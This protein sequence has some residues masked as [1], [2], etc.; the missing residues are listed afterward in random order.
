[1]DPE[2][3]RVTYNVNNSRIRKVD[4][5][6]N[7]EDHTWKEHLIRNIFA[8]FDA[9]EILKIRLPNFEAD[10]FVAW[11]AEKHGMFT[12]KS[13]YNLALDLRTSKP[14][15]SSVAYLHLENGK[16]PVYSA[17]PWIESFA[18]TVHDVIS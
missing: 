3:E 9:E 11:T 18:H 13:A 7:Q 1:M 6:I 16:V 10:D 12:V 14:P 15:S 4:Q 2:G 17:N 8:P 5:L